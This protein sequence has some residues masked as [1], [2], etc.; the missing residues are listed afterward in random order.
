VRHRDG[1]GP[2]RLVRYRRPP[3][4]A[5]GG[6]P[7][8]RANAGRRLELRA[9]P[10]GRAQLVPHDEERPRRAACVRRCRWTPG[11]RNCDG[12]GT[13]PRVPA[14]APDVPLP[15]D[16]RCRR[17]SDDA[18]V[19]PPAL[20]PRHLAGTRLL[21]RAAAPADERL[22]DAVDAVVGKRRRDGRWPLQQRYPGR[23]WFEMEQVGQP[24]RW[25]TLRALRVSR[26]VAREQP[27]RT[28][29]TVGRPLPPSPT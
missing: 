22:R 20:A 29:R 26:P 24:S 27:L 12:R 28:I 10:E 14:G 17:R 13:G 25:N 2:T 9:V 21:P 23:T 4:G 6:L 3:P 11:G 8:G 19:V 15:S 5:A 16:R 7:A 18:P 1:A